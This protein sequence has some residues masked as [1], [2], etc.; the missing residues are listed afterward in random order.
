MKRML[1][2]VDCNS[3][4]CS[5]ERLFRS[6][7][8]NTPV[9][10][11]SNNDGCVI[12]RTQEA[13]DLG[14]GMGEPYFKVKALCKK[15]SVSIFSSNFALYTNI[16]NRVMGLLAKSAPA[17]EVYSVDEAFL[18]LTGIENLHA[19]GVRTKE[20]IL[21]YVGIPTAV[22]IA[23]TKVLAKIANRIAKKSSKA[24]GVVCLDSEELT[25]IALRRTAVEDIWGIGRASSGKLRALGIYTAFD[26]K[27]FSNDRVIRKVLTKV[28]LQIK[29]ELCG[30]SCFHFGEDIEKKKEVMC[31]RTFGKPITDK[32]SL[33][34]SIASYICNAAEKMRDQ[35]SVC[36]EITLF[37]RTSPFKASEQYYLFE[38]LKLANPTCDSR[39]I[40]IEAL[41]LLDRSYRDGFE[42]KKAGVKLSGFFD[43]SEY[44]VNL[45]WP[46]DSPKDIQT[47]KV[48][49]FITKKEGIRSL[50][51]ASCGTSGDSWR[52]N[53]QFKSP[54]YTTVWKD[55]KKFS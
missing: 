41:K 26:F 49:D 39:K 4:Y 40:I 13:K 31:S 53:R 9:V 45:F 8:R 18:D 43:S 32:E 22:G 6:D 37:A 25:D 47:M 44:Q 7:L 17:I 46:S 50:R 10:V 52:M 28:G 21:Q 3:F 11:L 42:Y 23:P 27:Y 19:F 14:I 48:L 20:M 36:T 30:V 24:D 51:I 54:E 5:C 16:S 55:L 34:E 35:D 2:L 15:H 1:A 38:R 29:Q 12:A 33:K